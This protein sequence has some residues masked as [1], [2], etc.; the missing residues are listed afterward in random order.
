MHCA[1]VKINEV[2]TEVITYGR[3]IEEGIAAHGKRDIIIVITGNPGVPAFYKEFAKTLQL[4][5]PTEV[6]I[7]IIGH[8]GHTKPPDN[9]PD[10]Y[11]DTKTG[12]HLY[13]MKGNL[14]H[15][16]CLVLF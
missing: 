11:P 6:P 8:T 10:F 9:L 13:D 12:R 7:W 3:W 15:K 1:T 16:V 2:P 14:E 4:K 5:L